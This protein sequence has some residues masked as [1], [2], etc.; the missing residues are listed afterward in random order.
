MVSDHLQFLLNQIGI[1]IKN[2]SG[3]KPGVLYNRSDLL[4][5]S[6]DKYEVRLERTEIIEK[7]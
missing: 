2:R 3:R 4:L 1:F 7:N 5:S 6:Y